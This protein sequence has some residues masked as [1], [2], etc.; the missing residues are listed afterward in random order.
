LFTLDAGRYALSLEV[1]ER[2]VPALELTPLPTAPD[3]VQGVFNLHG[4]IVP[5]MNLRRRFGLPERAIE[6]SDHLIVAQT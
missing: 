6:L 1:V 2:V 4:R 5:V 3:I